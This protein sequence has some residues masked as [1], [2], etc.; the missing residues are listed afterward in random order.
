M[1][2]FKDYLDDTFI[3]VILCTTNVDYG[4]IKDEKLRELWQRGEVNKFLGV[5]LE[6]DA[7]TDQK[8]RIAI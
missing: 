3:K 7:F 8:K 5:K 2:K 6:S 4:D 1:I